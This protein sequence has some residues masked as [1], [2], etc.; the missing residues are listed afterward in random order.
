[1]LHCP[2][3]LTVSSTAPS[4]SPVSSVE[5]LTMVRSPLALSGHAFDHIV[6]F[7]S[8]PPPHPLHGWFDYLPW[9]T[10]ELNPR[11]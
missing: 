10:L 9:R 2:I 6:C 5:G 8:R 7:S 11:T 3:P 1:M 4:L